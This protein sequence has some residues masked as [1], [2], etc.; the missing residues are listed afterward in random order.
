MNESR[1]ELPEFARK[2]LPGPENPVWAE[3]ND[4]FLKEAG[5]HLRLRALATNCALL[6]LLVLVADIAWKLHSDEALLSLSW[7]SLLMW[8][9][10]V[11]LMCAGAVAAGANFKV[12]GIAIDHDYPFYHLPRAY[13]VVGLPGEHD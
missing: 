10:G 6:A 12:S 7:L 3:R 4:A 13:L 5:P 2:L 8:L 1:L 11:A 9:S